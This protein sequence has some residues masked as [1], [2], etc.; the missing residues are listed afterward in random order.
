MYTST[1]WKSG[2]RGGSR[3]LWTNCR[4]SHQTR[5]QAAHLLSPKLEDVDRVEEE[6]QG[7]MSAFDG[8]E[9]SIRAFG[10]EMEEIANVGE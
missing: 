9:P 1:Q 4:S 5:T 7:T 8:V 2:I 6:R 10:S 3:S